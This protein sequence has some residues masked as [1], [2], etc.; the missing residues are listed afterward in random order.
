MVRK[1]AKFKWACPGSKTFLRVC[2]GLGFNISFTFTKL[3]SLAMNIHEQ[4]HIYLNLRDLAS[5]LIQ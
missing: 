4:F 1:L 5:F 2:Q 3:W